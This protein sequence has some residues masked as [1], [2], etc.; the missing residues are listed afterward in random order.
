M[1]LTVTVDYATSDGNATAGTDYEEAT[2]TL[3][4]AD[5]DSSNKTFPIIIIDNFDH[6]GDK[7]VNLELTNP[8]G[9]PLLA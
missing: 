1:A 3:T 2:G 6:D 8:T 7:T 9:E 4:W 5:S